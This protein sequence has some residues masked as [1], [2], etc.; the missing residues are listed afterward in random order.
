MK[1]NILRQLLYCISLIAVL[2]PGLLRADVNV[3]L[4]GAT[5]TQ[6]NIDALIWLPLECSARSTANAQQLIRSCSS[7]NY[8]DT[9][10]LVYNTSVGRCLS[11]TNYMNSTHDNVDNAYIVYTSVS[12]NLITILDDIFSQNTSEIVVFNG[13]TGCL[14]PLQSA[15]SGAP[16]PP[17]PTDSDGDGIADSLD[18]CVNTPNPGQEDADGDGVGDACDN[19]TQQSNASQLDTDSDNYGNACDGDLNNDAFVN[20]LDLGL[21]KL[22]FFTVGASTSDF[23]GDGIVNSLDVGLF[24]Q[25]FF[26]PPGPSGLVN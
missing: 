12:G 20:S 24:K 16:P 3:I 18:N 21:F 17:P 25:M 1:L 2:T 22:A 15:S 11:L 4:K 10:T 5:V 13:G 7:F 26:Q 9:E 14:Y 19:C 8:S 23:N 6:R